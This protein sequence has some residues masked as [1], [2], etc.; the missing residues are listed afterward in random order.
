MLKA[1]FFF[2]HLTVNKFLKTETNCLQFGNL[3][4]KINSGYHKHNVTAH[5]ML[6]AILVQKQ[7]EVKYTHNLR[8]L[9]KCVTLQRR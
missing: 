9:H 1:V 8:Y 4:E 3:T 7:A 5:K 2:G 6:P